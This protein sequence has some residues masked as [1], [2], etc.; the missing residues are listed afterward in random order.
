MYY[1]RWY[2]DKTLWKTLQNQRIMIE[3]VF[4]WNALEFAL[5]LEICSNECPTKWNKNPYVFYSQNIAN[6]EE[7]STKKNFQAN[8]SYFW[9][10]I[11]QPAAL[12]LS[13][14]M[15]SSWLTKLLLLPPSHIIKEFDQTTDRPKNQNCWCL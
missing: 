10:V 12:Y 13:I 15:S 5:L 9:R 8:T 2:I 1:G 11:G 7:H 4:K 6:F 3:E 14:K